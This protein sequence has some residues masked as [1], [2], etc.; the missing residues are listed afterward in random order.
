M[1]RINRESFSKE[2]TPDSIE[3]KTSDGKPEEVF[4]LSEEDG[5][6]TE[7]SLIEREESRKKAKVERKVAIKENLSKL[8]QKISSI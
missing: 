4:H 3:G 5:S 8:I 1:E 7:G 6:K 2:S